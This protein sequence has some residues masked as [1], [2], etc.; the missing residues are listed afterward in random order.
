[1]LTPVGPQKTSLDAFLTELCEPGPLPVVVI[2]DV[3]WAD[4]A[5][6]DLLSFLAR[7]IRELAALL[8]VSY[9]N[10]ELADTHPLRIALGHLAVQRC[11]SRLRLA[12]LSAQA[13]R[14]L[15]VGCGVDPAELYSVTGGNPF[16]VRAVLE[17]GLGE[18]PCSVRDVVLARAARLEPIARQTLEAAALIGGTVAATH[19][20]TPDESART[21]R[22]LPA[23]AHRKPSRRSRTVR[24]AGLPL[25][26]GARAARCA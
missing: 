15:S 13:V 2:E 23:A 18:V 3:H 7:R 19:R 5:A 14:M 8:I 24:C 9:R 6:L 26:R 12:P 16:Y 21:G 20:I 1:M 17:A 10:D 11:T 25:R 4:E 22:A